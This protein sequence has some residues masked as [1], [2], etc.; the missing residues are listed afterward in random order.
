LHC[1]VEIFKLCH[2]NLRN[3]LHLHGSVMY[4]TCYDI[5]SLQVYVV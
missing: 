1:A 2:L 5:Q 3:D 4:E